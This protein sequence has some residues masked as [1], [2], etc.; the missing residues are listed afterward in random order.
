M[1]DNKI[2]KNS[3]DIMIIKKTKEENTVAIKRLETKIDKLDKEME[4][5]NKKILDAVDEPK[6]QLEKSVNLMDCN[7]CQMSFNRHVDLENH[8]RSSHEK[9]PVYQCDQ[10]EKSFVLRWRL[11]KH[12]NLHTKKNV[13]PSHYFNNNKNC[14]FEE[15]GCK[16]LH[17]AS[18]NCEFS[19]SCRRRL[20]PWTLRREH[21][22][23]K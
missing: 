22:H 17:V 15:Y 16:F 19:S 7:V 6:S 1:I 18:K 9:H 3:D 2:V 13:S 20:C 8:I 10:C 11:K 21:N 4:E 23:Q 12:I 5:T 14:P